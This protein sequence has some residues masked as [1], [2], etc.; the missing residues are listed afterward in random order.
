MYMFCTGVC[1]CCFS[2][3]KCLYLCTC[4]EQI[5]LKMK[6]NFITLCYF[7]D[8]C[9][10]DCCYAAKQHW[11]FCISSGWRATDCVLTPPQLQLQNTLLYILQATELHWKQ[12]AFLN[13]IFRP[14]VCWY[15]A[16]L[17]SPCHHFHLIIQ[18]ARLACICYVTPLIYSCFA[19]RLSLYL[20]VHQSSLTHH[21]L[22]LADILQFNL[23]VLQLLGESRLN[24]LCFEPP[25]FALLKL[26]GD[27]ESALLHL[28]Q[29]TRWHRR[30]RYV[31]LRWEYLVVQALY[32]VFGA[33]RQ[34][35][36]WAIDGGKKQLSI[37]Q[38]G[39]S[40]LQISPQ[41]LLHVEVSVPHLWDEEIG[42]I[43]PQERLT[44]EEISILSWV[45]KSHF[46][47]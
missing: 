11:R 27:T 10:P 35:L 18:W 15:Q 17:K 44:S 43:L 3:L 40:P 14:L 9:N 39:M 16:A 25:R 31:Q 38:Q 32:L 1:I 34:V 42:L 7:P 4:A 13:S 45:E 20:H 19:S 22:L 8:Y 33:I 30:V 37:S 41:L 24:A 47:L 36:P 5:S 2:K 23:S 29:S 26:I 28:K 6:T 21:T 46:S 12:T